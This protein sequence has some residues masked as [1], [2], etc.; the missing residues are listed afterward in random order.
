MRYR[1]IRTIPGA[2]ALA[3]IL[4][5]QP[6]SAQDEKPVVVTV[7]LGFVNT[8]GNSE[9]TTLNGGDKLVY[10]SAPWVFTQT[11]NVVYGETEGTTTTSQWQA[12]GRLDYQIR[13]RVSLFG[14]GRFERNTFAGIRRRFEEAV[15]VAATL[16]EANRNKLTAEAGVAYNQQTSDQTGVTDNF[17]SGRAAAEFRRDLTE[18]AFL[19][20]SGEFLPNFEVS[21]DYRVN[22]IA[23]LVAPISRAIALKVSYEVRYD[24]LP[25]PTFETTDRI[26]TTGLQIV[27]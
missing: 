11:F 4:G 20:L 21:E 25:E 27:F 9:V 23:A 7:D 10:T 19:T 8:A 16:L 12:G 26:L 22:G 2:L 14:Q 1:N 6:A 13:P 18:T 24:H 5:A 3:L 17:T 15:G